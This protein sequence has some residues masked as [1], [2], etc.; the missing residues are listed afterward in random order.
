MQNKIFDNRIFKAFN[1]MSI[2]GISVQI[3]ALILS[4]ILSRVYTIENFGLFGY[5][6]SLTS[7]I[8][9]FASLRLEFA[10]F[11]K[12][13]YIEY[14]LISSITV[15]LIISLISSVVVFCWVST[16]IS[17]FLLFSGIFFT[18]TYQIYSQLTIAKLEYKKQSISRVFQGV[19][20]YSLV[21]IFGL[22]YP[23]KGLLI[24][25]ILGQI[26]GIAYLAQNLKME[27]GSLH[28]NEEKRIL[29]ENKSFCVSSTISC[30]L[31]W[32]VPLAPMFV[33]KAIYGTGVIG[34]YFFIAQSIQAPI[35]IIRRS[36]LN[37]VTSELNNTI[38]FNSIFKPLFFKYY[39][40]FFFL[41]FAVITSLFSIT[42]FYGEQMIGFVFGE[43]WKLGGT[44]LCFM[45][46]YY[47]FDLF[48]QPFSHLLNLWGYYKYTYSIQ[49]IQFLIIYLISLLAG[50]LNL[51]FQIYLCL[52]Y[53]FIIFCYVLTLFCVFYCS[54]KPKIDH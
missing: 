2:A 23:N 22:F 54:K 52:H 37:I 32:S 13:E 51:P 10:Y 26:I 20:Q 12:K 36:I 35:A 9:V 45:V 5:F 42:Y 43:Q 46:V 1:Q 50:Y 3:L 40:L 14:F 8:P 19:V 28:W 16:D 11:I 21:L 24:S 44:F 31:Q 47:I 34:I 48:L 49:T 15:S 17:V 41:F 4:P 33:G 30:A 25:Y 53:S 6:T 29:K 27:V 39:R 38:I 7:L 18:S